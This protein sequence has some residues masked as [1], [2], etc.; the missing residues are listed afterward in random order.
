MNNQQTSRGADGKSSEE[1]KSSQPKAS[2]MPGQA[3]IEQEAHETA[4]GFLESKHDPWYKIATRTIFGPIALPLVSVYYLYFWKYAISLSSFR[5]AFN[6][7]ALYFCAKD[8]RA[9][10]PVKFPLFWWWLANM[11]LVALHDHLVKEHICNGAAN[12]TK[13]IRLIQGIWNVCRKD[14]KTMLFFLEEIQWLKDHKDFLKRDRKYVMRQMGAVFPKSIETL[15]DYALRF[16]SDDLKL[17][18]WVYCTVREVVLND[19]KRD[20]SKL[21]DMIGVVLKSEDTWK[22]FITN[23]A[24]V[25]SKVITRYPERMIEIALDYNDKYAAHIWAKAGQQALAI[26]QLRGSPDY[27]EKMPALLAE[28]CRLANDAGARI[29]THYL[30]DER[31]AE[32]AKRAAEQRE[33]EN[34]RAAEEKEVEK[35][36][37]KAER[38]AKKAAEM[39]VKNDPNTPKTPREFL[40]GRLGRFE[41][42]WAKNGKS[43]TIHDVKHRQFYRKLSA[44]KALNCLTA[45]FVEYGDGVQPAK[46]ILPLDDK[47]WKG[48]FNYGDLQDFYNEQTETYSEACP[49]ASADDKYQHPD[50][51]RIIPDEKPLKRV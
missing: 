8:G 35:Q 31:K 11:M 34:R 51:R 3:M 14:G 48:S 38:K 26:I 32:E 4:V 46:C 39:A 20:W 15:F 28:Y 49:D 2:S 41:L 7:C 40:R 12:C 1:K 9:P 18:L 36:K 50:W 25:V 5:A 21:I 37:R 33:Q 23:F 43:L 22:H 17:V 24:E 44:P 47:G 42:M 6:A 27:E 30:D 45:L 29:Y 16:E 10:K 19:K 13:S